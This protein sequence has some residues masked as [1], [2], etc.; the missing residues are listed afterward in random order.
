MRR[1]V[2]AGVGKMVHMDFWEQ[3]ICEE[4][5]GHC[6]HYYY[7]LGTYDKAYYYNLVHIPGL[8]AIGDSN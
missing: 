5:R 8:C 2:E 7:A 3:Y 6:E 4:Y 1:I